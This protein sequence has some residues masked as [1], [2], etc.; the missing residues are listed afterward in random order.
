MYVRDR[1]ASD[2]IPSLV[3]SPVSLGF[4]MRQ[5]HSRHWGFPASTPGTALPSGGFHCSS[6][7]Q[8]DLYSHRFSLYGAESTSLFKQTSLF[9]LLH[10]EAHTPRVIHFSAYVKGNYILCNSNFLG[11]GCFFGVVGY[12]LVSKG[13]RRKSKETTPKA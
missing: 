8:V 6:G 9:W 2:W 3:S 4:C 1:G 5:H 13:K 11:H 12:F 10:Q 7:S